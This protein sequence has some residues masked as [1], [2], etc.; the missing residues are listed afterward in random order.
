MYNIALY[1]RHRESLSYYASTG[2]TWKKDR[3]RGEGEER[4]KTFSVIESLPVD[5]TLTRFC[6]YLLLFPPLS[7][8]P[9]FG[10]SS[11]QYSTVEAVLLHPHK[12]EVP[13]CLTLSISICLIP[14]SILFFSTVYCTFVGSPFLFKKGEK[15]NLSPPS[16]SISL[17]HLLSFPCYLLTLLCTTHTKRVPLKNVVEPILAQGNRNQFCC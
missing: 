17:S 6:L 2:S 7:K 16:P 14:K 13:F 10:S 9:F 5:K 11:V 8:Q 4:A 1:I 12:K 15:Q 3:G